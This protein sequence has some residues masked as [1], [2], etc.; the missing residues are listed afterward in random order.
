MGETHFSN[1]HAFIIAFYKWVLPFKLPHSGNEFIDML[2]TTIGSSLYTPLSLGI[3][4][5]Y[6]PKRGAE[7][8]NVYAT[9]LGLEP[10]PVAVTHWNKYGLAFSHTSSRGA[11]RCN[12]YL[13]IST[14][15]TLWFWFGTEQPEL[16]RTL[17]IIVE[18]A[19]GT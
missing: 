4:H 1:P 9:N 6:Y 18:G 13:K 19:W 15:C 8:E 2:A 11:P 10:V 7:D 3:S 14:F 16:P 5:V 12:D 17:I